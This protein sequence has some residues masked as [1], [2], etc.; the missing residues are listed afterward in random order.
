M[1]TKRGLFYAILCA[2]VVAGAAFAL[3]TASFAR[4]GFFQ[5]LLIGRGGLGL[6]MG[7][8]GSSNADVVAQANPGVVTVAA[9]RAIQTEESAGAENRVQRGTGAGFIVD[10][11]GLIV[12]NHHV[13][14][15]ADRIRV[16]LHD[17]RT[18]IA[19]VIGVDNATDL[20]LI[21]ITTNNLEPIHLGDSDALRVGDPV[22][23][24]GNPLEYERSVTAGIVSAL[25]RKVYEAE[26][27]ENFIQTDAA[28]NRGNSGGPLLNQRGEVIGVN[29]VIR[30]DG[31]GISF[32]VPSNVVKRVI[33]Q[34][35]ANG[36]VARG[37]LGLTPA[38][39]TP[40]LRDGLR[41]GDLQGVVVA[42]V[43]NNLPAAKAG[44]QPYDVITHFNGR[45]IRQSD[46]FFSCVANTSPQQRV[47]IAVVRGGQS[48]K[49]Y[50]TL[51]QRPSEGSANSPKVRPASDKRGQA[52]GH[53]IGLLLGF[54]VR[55]NT[56]EALRE[57][58][59]GKTSDEITGGV[60][61]SDVDP[62]GPASDS[63]L[64]AGY[65]I[66]EANRHPIRCLEDFHKATERLREGEILVIRFT[67]PYQR[68]IQFATIKVGES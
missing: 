40:E 51:E 58:R 61:V 5:S 44:I 21:K 26:P 8:S 27:F 43:S 45:S 13:I 54:S 1:N 16:K 20:A 6:A 19:T 60:I 25:G 56:P 46:D 10:P 42:D 48:L 49:F 2:T 18:H 12:T 57:L 39:L 4:P 23:A 29:T 52:G 63:R 28:I 47:E 41:L 62:L 9:T 68:A 38:S 22:I 35:R 59:V 33:S 53:N 67:S 31:R 24:I 3:V 50:P 15:N 64:V 17:G 7:G 34:L 30:S 37:Y 66:L 55:E 14:V 32:A 65:I 36:Y 11:D